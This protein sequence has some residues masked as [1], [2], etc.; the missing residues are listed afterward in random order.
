MLTEDK[1][2]KNISNLVREKGY[3]ILTTPNGEFFSNKLPKFSDCDDPTVFENEQF[4]PNSDGH[5]FLLHFD[6]IKELAAKSGFTVTEHTYFNNPMTIGQ[7]RT[8]HALPFVPR[9]FVDWVEQKTSSLQYM[10]MGKKINSQIL[11]VL[12]KTE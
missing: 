3:I 6:E 7:F 8:W 2:L 12:Q 10:K 1:L 4:K 5:I 9:F 11:V